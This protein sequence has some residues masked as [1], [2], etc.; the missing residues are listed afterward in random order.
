MN[1]ETI[2][3]YVI[4]I[5]IA[6]RAKD[7]IRAISRRIG[8]S[9]AW[10]YKWVHALA[11]EGVFKI[12]KRLTVNKKNNFYKSTIAY[13]NEVLA[14]EVSFFYK[15]L[16]L[17]GITYC[18]TLTDAVF[19]W[20]KGGYNIARY[21][22]WYPVFIRVRSKDKKIFEAYCET[23]GLPTEK[24]RG[25]FYVAGFADDFEISFVDGVPADSLEQ[26]VAFM[27][28]NIY[29]FQPAMEM[30]AEL[31][32]IKNKTAYREQATNV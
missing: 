18:F 27:Q 9:Y 28:V 19:V 21:K 14:K 31:Y 16:P 24:R 5:I 23:L 13:I 26:T 7:S 1:V 11:D 6:A 4:K 20:T 12:Q 30:I 17:F 15:V 2:N 25:V 29:N 8:L 3:P 22:R 32:H 10:T